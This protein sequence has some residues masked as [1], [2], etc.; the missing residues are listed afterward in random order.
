MCST[1]FRQCQELYKYS[2][3]ILSFL[4][5]Y[6][7][8]NLRAYLPFYFF[9]HVFEHHFVIREQHFTMFF[10]LYFTF[11]S[12]FNQHLKAK[13]HHS[14]P[15]SHILLAVKKQT[16]PLRQAKL[17]GGAKQPP[18]E[19]LGIVKMGKTPHSYTPIPPQARLSES[20]VG[21]QNE[22]ETLIAFF[23]YG[24]MVSQNSTGFGNTEQHAHL[25]ANMIL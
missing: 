16:P 15:S 11:L 5:M 7:L 14:K 4:N 6:I 23:I 17:Q 9:L 12:S 8:C 2:K 13:S 22:S 1:S 20:K 25:Q 3:V 10:L 18:R 19:K 24:V 21:H